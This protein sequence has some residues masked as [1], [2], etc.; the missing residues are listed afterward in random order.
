VRSEL[1]AASK[2]ARLA[3]KDACKQA[4][5]KCSEGNSEA[6][7]VLNDAINKTTSRGA[8]LRAARDEA[9]SVLLNEL[10][11]GITS[12]VDLYR[13]EVQE[14]ITEDRIIIEQEVVNYFNQ[15]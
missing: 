3:I 5:D 4:L 9:N 14:N 10:N 12:V 8:F 2:I 11:V 7:K 6:N 13:A 15:F 1:E